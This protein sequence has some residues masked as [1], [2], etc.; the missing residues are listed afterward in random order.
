MIAC[1]VKDEALF[2]GDTPAQRIAADLFGDDFSTCMDKSYEELNQE[3]KT[4]SD[5]TQNQGQIRFMPGT[6][7]LIK[8]FIQWARD[9]RRLGRDPSTIAFPVENAP[10]LLRRY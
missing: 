2:G 8:A 10:T 7:R 5:L 9:E 6:K 1:G 4:Y 3:L